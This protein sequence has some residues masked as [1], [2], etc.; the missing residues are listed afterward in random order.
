MEGSHI[1]TR[2]THPNHQENTATTDAIL[3]EAERRIEDRSHQDVPENQRE[4]IK[5]AL[6]KYCELDTMA[7]V[8]I[9]DYWREE[10][11][12]RMM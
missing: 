4:Q 9:W 1:V 12:M 6:L 10:L 3:A 11:G 8:M 2:E 7:M 5:Q